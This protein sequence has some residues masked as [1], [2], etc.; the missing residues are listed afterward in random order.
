MLNHQH[1]D[2]YVLLFSDGH[3]HINLHQDF[4]KQ[5]KRL[6]D[7]WAR[8]RGKPE[9]WHFTYSCQCLEGE[10]RQLDAAYYN[11]RC[12]FYLSRK[13]SNLAL[14]YLREAILQDPRSSEIRV[15]QR[16]ALV[17]H[18][19]WK[20]NPVLEDH[21]LM[22]RSQKIQPETY[23]DPHNSTA[24]GWFRN[25]Y[26]SLIRSLHEEEELLAQVNRLTTCHEWSYSLASGNDRSCTIETDCHVEDNHELDQNQHSDLHHNS[27]TVSRE[28]GHAKLSER[29]EPVELADTPI[30]RRYSELSGESSIQ[31]R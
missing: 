5:I 13:D 8:K 18:R 19:H 12:C 11:R 9:G 17:A 15:T 31:R 21:L 16:L 23:L 30:Q 10:Q 25:Q 14:A 1:P 3:A 22:V 24:D 6:V 29:Q 7:V 2:E 27:T 26:L 4:K 20:N 28:L